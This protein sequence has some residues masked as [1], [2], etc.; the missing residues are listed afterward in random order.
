MAISTD[1]KPTIYRNLCENM[2][3]DLYNMVDHMIQHDDG[4]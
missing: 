4:F 2:G 3:P 1:L